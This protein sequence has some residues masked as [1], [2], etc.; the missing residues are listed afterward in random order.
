MIEIRAVEDRT[1]LSLPHLLP[2]YATFQSPEEKT[3]GY[4]TA[5]PASRTGESGRLGGDQLRRRTTAVNPS[6]TSPVWKVNVM[7]S[8][9][10]V[11]DKT[12]EIHQY[13]FRKPKKLALF[14]PPVS[15][16]LKS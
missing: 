13:R 3:S 4:L 15:I 9:L 5:P 6:R 2:F 16:L 10:F 12:W 11:L 14:R 7:Y 8:L 1:P